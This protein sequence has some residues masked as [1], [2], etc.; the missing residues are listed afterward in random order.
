ML[1]F[2]GFRECGT[3]SEHRAPTTTVPGSITVAGEQ[4]SIPTSVI[5][6]IWEGARVGTDVCLAG[7][8]VQ[9]ICPQ[10]ARIG[11]WR[12]LVPTYQP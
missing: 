4:Y 6:D 2:Q 9:L 12:V 11:A 3:L 8:Y 5:Q 10:S 1:V 7:T